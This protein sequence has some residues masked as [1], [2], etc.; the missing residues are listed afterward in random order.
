MKI[1]TLYEQGN[2]LVIAIPREYIVAMGWKK[3]E[4][5]VM[6]YDDDNKCLRIY[7][8][9]KTIREGAKIN[10]QDNETRE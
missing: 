1:G 3:K 8:V 6:F 7:S 9:T 4:Q 5:I 10:E 2:S